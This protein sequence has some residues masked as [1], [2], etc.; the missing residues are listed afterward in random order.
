MRK[1]LISGIF[2]VA[3]LCQLAPANAAVEHDARW[4][5]AR[6]DALIAEAVKHGGVETI[7][8]TSGSLVFLHHEPGKDDY[9]LT[10]T[11]SL[12]NKIRFICVMQVDQL[13][14]VCSDWNTGT[15]SYATRAADDDPADAHSWHVSRTPP[16]LSPSNA[17]LLSA[18]VAVSFTCSPR[19]SPHIC[20]LRT[21]DIAGGNTAIRS[22]AK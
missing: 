13:V 6:W 22:S 1:L 2:A 16:T 4:K 5:D 17:F 18:P 3:L 21:R 20:H 15:L 9:Y 12:D 10:F 8:G 11:H 7:A 19:P 14:S